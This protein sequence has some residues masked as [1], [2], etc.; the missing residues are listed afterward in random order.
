M[1]GGR[2][3]RAIDEAIH[4][5][6]PEY[7]RPVRLSVASNRNNVE[8]DIDGTR[9]HTPTTLEVAPGYHGLGVN[10]IYGVGANRRG[11]A[12][13]TLDFGLDPRDVCGNLTDNQIQVRV[14]PR[15]GAKITANY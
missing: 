13:W 12:N 1:F 4:R 10:P 7:N 6:D 9:Y 2:I 11:F 5:N 8:V 3:F 15:T 14:R